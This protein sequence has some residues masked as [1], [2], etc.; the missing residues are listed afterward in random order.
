MTT[1]ASAIQTITDLAN[2]H[3]TKEALRE[4]RKKYS[5]DSELDSSAA[6]YGKNEDERLLFF[7]DLAQ[8]LWTDVG[9][10]GGLDILHHLLFL[11]GWP[12]ANVGIDWRRQRIIYRPQSTLEAAFYALLTHNHL[13][14]RCA[15]PDCAAPFFIAERVDERYCSTRCKRIGRLANKREWMREARRK[16]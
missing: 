2:L 8:R 7:R 12:G 1:N 3:P 4:F 13:A 15:N 11:S 9:D 10:A 6:K 5:L 16:G 14:K